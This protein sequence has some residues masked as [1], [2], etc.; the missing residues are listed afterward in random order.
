MWKR[1]KSRTSSGPSEHVDRVDHGLDPG[2]ARH[3]RILKLRWA[4]H[5]L[6]PTYALI[7][8]KGTLVRTRVAEVSQVGRNTQG[9]TLIR[10]PD[11]EKLAGVVKIESE[12][13]E[14]PTNGTGESGF[15]VDDAVGPSGAAD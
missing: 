1:R 11:D 13:D 4:S 9:L 3:C 14:A 2:E 15:S 10:L 12:D 5:S 8:D 6:S 7:S